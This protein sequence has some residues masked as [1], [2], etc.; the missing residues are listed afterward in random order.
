M[1][2]IKTHLFILRVIHLI[3]FSFALSFSAEAAIVNRR[4]AKK[5][6]SQT[7]PRKEKSE[8]RL[9]PVVPA[10]PTQE[11]PAAEQP[12][13]T[14][15][16][17]EKKALETKA[18]FEPPGTE[19]RARFVV[20]EPA[21]SELLER[22][23]PWGVSVG[24]N[25]RLNNESDLLTGLRMNQT[26]SA[27][28]IEG[29][30]FAPPLGNFSSLNLLGL[31]LVFD[32]DS[33]TLIV[34]K[35]SLAG[36]NQKL[37]GSG[38]GFQ[39]APLLQSQ[40]Q[41][42]SLSRLWLQPWGYSYRQFNLKVVSSSSLGSSTLSLTRKG[43]VS[44]IGG[45]YSFFPYMHSGGEFVWGWGQSYQSRD[46]VLGLSRSGEWNFIEPRLLLSFRYP[47]K[48]SFLSVLSLTAG[49][50]MRVDF[51][52]SK[53]PEESFPG[54]KYASQFSLKFGWQFQPPDAPLSG[55]AR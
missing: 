54:R 52:K 41:K 31:S 43:S 8:R 9:Q 22:N 51:F 28:S 13:Q 15:P 27:F 20:L 26:A 46:S 11:L 2:K 53:D 21:P 42:G 17:E 25:Q 47:A 30:A 3:I 1:R 39:F 40:Y 18:K 44:M 14:D 4:P 36:E 37:E 10:P 55:G 19:K 48:K 12:I 29:Q 45:E 24:W 49:F 6:S 38:Y 50:G 32:A 7:S 5:P 23:L 34:G 33:P 16:M 35:D